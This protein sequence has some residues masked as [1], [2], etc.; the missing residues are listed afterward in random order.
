MGVL[1]CENPECGAVGRGDEDR[2]CS[3]CQHRL[4]HQC[5]KCRAPIRVSTDALCWA[6]G[7]PYKLKAP[8]P[9][10][11]LRQAGQQ[12]AEGNHGQRE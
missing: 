10:G 2:Q 7:A 5:R 6:C 4:I 11:F 8:R 3:Q 9:P 12:G 1:V